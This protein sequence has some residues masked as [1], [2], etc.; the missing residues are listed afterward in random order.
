MLVKVDP[1]ELAKL[2]GQDS[3]SACGEVAACAFY[4][5]QQIPHATVCT[6]AGACRE[7]TPHHRE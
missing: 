7:S 2:P 4:L 5:G 1:A 6:G 3:Q